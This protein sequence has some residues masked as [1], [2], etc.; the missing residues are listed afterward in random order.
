MTDH[1]KIVMLR[2]ALAASELELAACRG[3]ESMVR[4]D[5][6]RAWRAVRDPD[7]TSRLIA[8][9][10][11]ADLKRLRIGL[12]AVK[13]ELACLQALMDG[14]GNPAPLPALT[15]AQIDGLPF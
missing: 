5:A 9:E 12:H 8:A 2:A 7:A 6:N 10:A 1:E 13:L 4:K 15:D 3:R 11:L 14:D